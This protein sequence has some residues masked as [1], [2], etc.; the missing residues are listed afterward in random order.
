MS[1]LEETNEIVMDATQAI[2]E[3]INNMSD[4]DK[5][6]YNIAVKQLESSFDMVKSIGFMDYINKNN[7]VIKKDN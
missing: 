4:A 6:A 5:I 2:E 3:Y 1:N 7:I